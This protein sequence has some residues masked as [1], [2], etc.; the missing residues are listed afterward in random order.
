MTVRCRNSQTPPYAMTRAHVARD[1]TGG[2]RGPEED[3]H[4]RL[5]SDNTGMKVGRREQTRG[6]DRSR[7]GAG[8]AALT[9]DRTDG[10]TG[11]IPRERAFPRSRWSARQDQVP[12]TSVPTPRNRVPKDAKRGLSVKRRNSTIMVRGFQA[13]LSETD[14][15]SQNASKDMD[16]TAPS[17]DLT[18]PTF[19]A[20]STPQLQ[21][22]R[23]SSGHVE[24]SPGQTACKMTQT[25]KG[26]ATSQSTCSRHRGI[27]SPI[28]DRRSLRH[29]PISGNQTR[30]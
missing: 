5:A 29:P 30:F 18:E 15:T 22:A 25:H 28:D 7:G 27:S 9:P 3:T 13:S 4:Q 26:A 21:E 23:S 8:A 1:G 24:P 12:V 10:Q 2:H 11:H 6:T 16:R 17:G 20:P 19:T 14:R